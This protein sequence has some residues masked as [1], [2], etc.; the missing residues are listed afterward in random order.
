MKEIMQKHLHECKHC[1]WIL[2]VVGVVMLLIGISLSAHAIKVL[3]ILIAIVAIA[4]GGFLLYLLGSKKAKE[5]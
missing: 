1:P 2:I 3:W 5:D 4:G